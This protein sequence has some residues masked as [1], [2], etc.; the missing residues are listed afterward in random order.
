MNYLIHFEKSAK[1]LIFDK[2]EYLTGSFTFWGFTLFSSTW[3]NDVVDRILDFS[4]AVILVVAT[5]YIKKLLN[6]KKHKKHKKH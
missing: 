6:R 2:L 3:V 1:A 4:I 5:H